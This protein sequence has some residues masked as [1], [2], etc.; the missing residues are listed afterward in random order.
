MS[1]ALPV[2]EAQ[3]NVEEEMAKGSLLGKEAGVPV[4][5]GAGKE[6]EV[7]TKLDTPAQE[8]MASLKALDSTKDLPSDPKEG[9]GYQIGPNY[10]VWVS[11][12]WVTRNGIY[13]HPGF[14]AYDA[15]IG[16]ESTQVKTI[17]AQYPEHGSP[18][19]IVISGFN[20]TTNKA[21]E[22]SD[23]IGPLDILMQNGVP[24]EVG[25]NGVTVEDL[26]KAA[27]I[28]VQGYQTGQFACVENEKLLEHIDAALAMSAARL[29]RRTEEGTE[30]TLTGN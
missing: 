29:L 22:D 9:E 30:G 19:R 17:D 28:A 4:E 6:E 3:I 21:R 5:D 20:T 10:W 23:V 18:K 15:E 8:A 24:S 2:V 1:T 12:E 11:G 14:E 7:S 25:Q 27:K 16:N 26:L 13:G